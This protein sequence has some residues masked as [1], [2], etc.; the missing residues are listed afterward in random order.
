MWFIFVLYGMTYRSF[1]GADRIL[2]FAISYTFFIESLFVDMI[3]TSALCVP[4]FRNES[5]CA[6]TDLNPSREQ[7]AGAKA[8][9]WLSFTFSSWW[10]LRLSHFWHGFVW[11]W[12]LFSCMKWV[13]QGIYRSLCGWQCS[14]FG[15]WT[16]NVVGPLCPFSTSRCGT[17]IFFIL[18]DHCDV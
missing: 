16:A 10:W 13:V 5:L 7:P 11:W 4:D 17:Q 14:T 6:T 3:A 2:H 1:E 15:R 18:V 12:I 9:A 8:R